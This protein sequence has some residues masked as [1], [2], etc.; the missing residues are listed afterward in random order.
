MNHASPPLAAVIGWP[1]AHSKSPILHGYW[2][3]K[4]GI[5]GFYVPIGLAPEDFNQGLN[6]LPR[7]GFKGAN[8]TIPHKLAA[9]AQADV[10]TERARAIGAANTLFF[11][12]DTGI[13]ADNTDGYGFLANLQ[14]NAPGWDPA[15]GPAVV[16]GAGGAARAVVHSLLSAG[17]PELR[18]VNRTR[19]RAEALAEVFGKKVQV[20]DW[21]DASG[22]VDGAQTLVNTTSMGMAGNPDVEIDLGAARDSALV[23]DIVYTPLETGFLKLAKA[24]GLQTVDGLG[25]LLHQAVPGFERWFGHTPEVDDGLRAAMLNG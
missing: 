11:D 10:V 6:S 25:M 16:L 23:T 9:L 12:A 3:K 8:V 7:L 1:I 4:Y 2:L 13:T 24:R 19:S 14:Q 18:L 5:K 17:V 20:I 15:A 22:A 21:A